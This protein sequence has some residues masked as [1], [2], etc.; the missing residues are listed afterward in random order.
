MSDDDD[1]DEDDDEPAVNVSDEVLKGM[2][3]A[4]ILKQMHKEGTMHDNLTLGQILERVMRNGKLESMTISDGLFVSENVYPGSESMKQVLATFPKYSI[5][6]IVSASIHRDCIYLNEVAGLQNRYAPTE[7]FLSSSNQKQRFTYLEDDILNLWGQ[8]YPNLVDIVPIELT[9]NLE[10][11]I[12]QSDSCVQA[13]VKEIIQLDTTLSPVSKKLRV[14]QSFT[15][16]KVTS[17]LTKQR[18]SPS[19][20]TVP[21]TFNSN[22]SNQLTRPS[23]GRL[24]CSRCVKTFKNDDDLNAH[25]ENSH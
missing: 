23:R 2:L 14:N 3:E 18:N 25:F 19:L 10:E 9:S 15:A 13:V 6:K 7:A 17:I 24:V 11:S 20:L 16:P 4:G 21:T 5:I 22:S 12:L 1:E 8:N